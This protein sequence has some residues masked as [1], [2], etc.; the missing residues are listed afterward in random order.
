MSSTSINEIRKRVATVLRE[1]PDVQAVFLF[2]S[3]AE[4][5]ATP[6]SDVDLAIITANPHLRAQRLDL[7]TALTAAGM[8]NVDLI[9]PDGRD[10]VLRYESIRQNCLVYARD[11]FDRGACY[12]RALREYLDFLP[13]LEIQR[14]AF[15][16]RL[17]NA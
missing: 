10:V 3:M 2:G 8:D 17:L 14:Q 15:K 11:N 12:A 16:R 9:F 7:L 6:G 4:G 1:F 13:Y 5:R